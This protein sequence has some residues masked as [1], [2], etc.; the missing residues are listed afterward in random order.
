MNRPIFPQNIECKMRVK[1]YDSFQKR[2]KVFSDDGVE[3]T[4]ISFHS[5]EFFND[6]V[7]C[8]LP[9]S[10]LPQKAQGQ[11]LS[12]LRFKYH[13]MNSILEVDDDGYI[14]VSNNMIYLDAS[15]KAVISY[16]VAMFITKL[17]SRVVYRYKYLVHLKFAKKIL[18][19]SLG[20]K[21]P[22]FV[23]LNCTLNDASIFEAKGREYIR[24]KMIEDAIKQVD[25]V[26]TIQGVAPKDGTVCVS[27]PIK[28]GKELT[29]S[30]YDPQ[31]DGPID[32]KVT[33]GEL[34]Y[35]YYWP[36]YELLHEV[37]K[38]QPSCSVLLDSSGADKIECQIGMSQSL[39]DFFEEYP[40]SSKY[41]KAICD[42]KLEE[43]LSG[44]EDGDLLRIEITP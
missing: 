2:K 1:F 15:E 35:L 20:K 7:N 12:E 36:I 5:R 22:D 37:N 11:R 44:G 10:W 8:G 4:E 34:L 16:Y 18:K 38:G 29:C 41:D 26:G 28:E 9:M 42:K 40:D 39:F 13:M 3:I 43:I 14:F 33:L 24:T 32:L 17:M 31:P 25:S 6:I 30:M 23:A 19:I 27:H 21:E